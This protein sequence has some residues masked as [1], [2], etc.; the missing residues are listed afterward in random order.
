MIYHNRSM[1]QQFDN[2]DKSWCFQF[3]PSNSFPGGSPQRRCRA[4]GR[5]RW[6]WWRNV[7]NGD[8]LWTSEVMFAIFTPI[9]Y[10]P[11]LNSQIHI[12]SYIMLYIYICTINIPLISP[13]FPCF[14]VKPPLFNMFDY[15]SWLYPHVGKSGPVKSVDAFFSSVSLWADKVGALPRQRCP[16]NRWRMKAMVVYGEKG[17]SKAMMYRFI[18]YWWLDVVTDV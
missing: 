4:C 9:W 16:V 17:D 5:S 15:L 6:S 12:D 11:F 13:R 2:D 8:Y 1:S 14:M 7:R 18:D 10:I 3:L